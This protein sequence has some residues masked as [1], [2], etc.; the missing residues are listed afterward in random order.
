MA[1]LRFFV[2][3]EG[4]LNQGGSGNDTV[5]NF[6]G[7]NSSNTIKGVDGD[8]LIS[9]ANQTTA[10][11]VQSTLSKVMSAGK[12][13]AGSFHAVYSGAYVSAGTINFGTLTAG[14]ASFSAGNTVASGTV[15]VLAQTGIQT[16]RGGRIAG[17]KG[18]DSIFL[19][20]QVSTFDQASVYGGAGNDIVGTY[21]SGANTA[22]DVSQF[23]GSVLKGGGGNDTVFVTVSASSATDF[24]VVGNNGIDSVAY[25]GATHETNSGFV[26]GGGGNDT[27]AF[28]V[29][30][31]TNTTLKGGDGD[32]TLNFLISTTTT[33]GL[34]DAGT[35]NDT[36]NLKFGTVSSTS[37][38]GG[39]G[40]DSIALSGLTDN[41]TNLLDAG[42]GN[43]TIFFQS[44]GADAISGSTVVAGAGNDSILFQV[45][46]AGVVQSGL[47]KGG[48][49]NDT[50]TLQTNQN[51]GSAGF[52]GSTVKGGAGADS[53]TISAVGGGG[54]GSGTFA[55]AKFNESTLSSMDTLTFSTAAISADADAAFNSSKILV[56]L[57]MGITTG[58]SGAGAVGQVSASGG[59]VVWS[60]Y[61]DNSL[62][63]RVSA[64][65]AGYT[66]TGDYAV[67]TTDNTTRYLFVQG[68]TTDLVARLS[69]E[70][71]LSAGLTT[72]TRSGNSIGFGF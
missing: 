18:N 63:A 56:N 44:A 53:I 20:D 19:G 6:T 47:I 70:D 14:S 55:Y 30:T 40:N 60:G 72:I 43:D 50:I 32:D 16:I 52:A 69:N 17:G 49:G 13:S 66:T 7:I 2:T 33:K 29:V 58:V 31:A 4:T 10:V 9:L 28:S 35:G 24:K 37:V 59:F 54:A 46:S 3:Q 12:G 21:N 26:G 23:S 1:D 61:S 64:I 67:F 25:S 22:G 57:S 65:D 27:V 36:V 62:T 15:Q 8:D 11:T 71:S 42:K 5:F 51:Q 41:G 68:G 39:E 34:V 38:Y 48:A 45:E